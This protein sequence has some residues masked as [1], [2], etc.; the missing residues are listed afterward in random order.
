MMPI[1]LQITEQ[2]EARATA[3]RRS[4]AAPAQLLGQSPISV[5]DIKSFP[6]STERTK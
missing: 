2:S 1:N 3:R 4:C 6:F 5:S